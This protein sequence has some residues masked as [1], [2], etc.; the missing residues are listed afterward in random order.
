[1][2]LKSLLFACCLSLISSAFADNRHA[3]AQANSMDA[4]SAASSVTPR[5]DC[6]VEIVNFS[7]QNVH[8]YAEYPDGYPLNFDIRR[9]GYD[10][11]HFI[12]MYFRGSCLR[13]IYVNIETFSGYP[14]YSGFAPA[15]QPIYIESY[16]GSNVKAKV[17]GK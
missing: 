12:D 8:V 2:K 17:R 15:G 16:F 10:T 1:M 5:N 11:S 14:V 7:D 6:E 4:K 13:S 9:Y 3:H